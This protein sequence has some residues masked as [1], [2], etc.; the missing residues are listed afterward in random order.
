MFGEVVEEEV[1]AEEYTDDEVM[2]VVAKSIVPLKIF[3]AN[4]MRKSRKEPIG[5]ERMVSHRHAIIVV[6][7]TTIKA[8]AQIAVKMLMWLRLQN[9]QRSQFYMLKLQSLFSLQRI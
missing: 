2:Q 8:G 5:Q 6:L 1:M 3:L 4:L 9:L 7:F